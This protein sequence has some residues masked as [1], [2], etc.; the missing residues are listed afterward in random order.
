MLPMFQGAAM[1]GISEA[2][3]ADIRMYGRPENRNGAKPHGQVG[4]GTIGQWL[5]LVY[6]NEDGGWG[7]LLQDAGVMV[8]V[9]NGRDRCINGEF[10]F[11]GIHNQ[12]CT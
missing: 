2:L 1:L 7:E 12:Y 4:C 9:R 8:E 10:I 5:E 6:L 11:K 3:F